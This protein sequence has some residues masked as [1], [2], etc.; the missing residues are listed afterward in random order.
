MTIRIATFVL[1]LATLALGTVSLPGTSE[2]ARRLRR[3]RELQ[4]AAGL[5]GHASLLLSADRE[6][7]QRHRRAAGLQLVLSAS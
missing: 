4:Q 6:Q 3:Q 5:Q 7:R 2:A 1:A